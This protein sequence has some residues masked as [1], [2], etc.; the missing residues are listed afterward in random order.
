MK[1]KMKRKNYLIWATVTLLLTV[2]GSTG[3]WA[4]SSVVSVGNGTTASS[5]LPSYPNCRYALS[6]QI[7]TSDE[8]GKSGLITSIAFYNY[9]TGSERNYDI[10]LSHTSKTTFNGQTDWVQVAADNKV[11]SGKVWLAQGV[12]TVI[13][14]DTPFQYNG[15]QNLLI[16]IDDNTGE[17]TGSN[18]NVGTY[19]GSG[20]QALYYYKQFSTPLNLDPAQTVTEEGAVYDRK[21]RLQL[22]FETYP[23]PYKLTAPEI[24]DVSAQ[25]QCSLRGDATAWNLRYRKVGETNWTTLDN[26]TER[27]KVIE[28]LTA[29]TKYEAQVQAVFAGG[30]NSDWTESLIFTTNCC[31]AEE[32]STVNYALRGDYTPWYDFAV[33]IMDVTDAAK[34]VEAAYLRAPSYEL[35]K[36]SISLCSNHT[37]QVNWIYDAEH[38]NVNHSFAFDLTYSNGDALYSMDYFEAPE[39]TATLTTFVMD[40]GDFD[41]VMPTELTA[42]ETYQDATLGWTQSDNAR[43]WLVT[44]SKDPN[45]DPDEPEED[46]IVLAER[47]PFVLSELEENTTYYCAVRAVEVE[48]AAEAAPSRMTRAPE[49][50]KIRKNGTYRMKRGSKWVFKSVENLSR[51]KKI[52]LNTCDRTSRPNAPLD[53]VEMGKSKTSV[54]LDLPKARGE[55]TKYNILKKTVTGEGTEV[56]LSDIKSRVLKGD[57][58][59]IKKHQVS[60]TSETTKGGFDNVIFVSAKKGSE[61]TFKMSQ[62]K[63]GA[64]HEPYAVGWM[65]NTK[66]GISKVEEI[67]DPEKV[68]NEKLEEL[69]DESQRYVEKKPTETKMTTKIVEANDDTE[70]VDGQPKKP[71]E[72]TGED[73]V[74]FIRHNKDGGGYLRVQEVK[75]TEP[76]N[77]KEWTSVS[78]PEGQMWYVDENVPLG[79]TLLM[80]SEPVY[81]DGTTGLNSPI[82][83]VTTPSQELAPKPGLFSIAPG[84]TA[85]FSK[86]NLSGWRFEDDFSLSEKQYTMMGNGNMVDGYPADQVDLFALSTPLNDWGTWYGY[87]DYEENTVARFQGSFV[88]WGESESVVSLIGGGW[89]TLS[90]SEW[91][92]VLSGRDNAESRKAMVTVSD[93]KGLVLLPDEWE[94]PSEVAL[95]SGGIYTDEQWTVLED[96]GAVFL[97]AAGQFNDGLSLSDVG[98]KGYYWSSTP[99][100]DKTSATMK[101]DAYM[102]TFDGS[103]ATDVGIVSRRTGGAVRLVKCDELSVTTAASGFTT[104]VS[105]AT[106]DLAGTEGLSGYYATTVD[107]AYSSVTLTSIS[108]VPAHTPV[109]LKGSPNTTYRIEVT[110]TSN[111]PPAD[112]LLKGSATESTELTAG[113]AY[114]LSGG[115]FVRNNAGTMPAGK[116]YLPAVTVSQARQLTI[117]FDDGEMTAIH[118]VQSSPRQTGIYNLQGQ[119]VRTPGKGLYIINGK[120]VFIK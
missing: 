77:V 30:K 66:L 49:K 13:D 36:G 20:N 39:E 27:S 41:F 76:E 114:I 69:V 58:E 82:V 97:P 102:M 89:T 70:G 55:E 14:F 101:D 45:F 81:N 37:Y 108:L 40:D 100:D 33:Q 32:Q 110:V 65:S 15:T 105:N 23:K 112:N 78:L 7:Y 79:S 17:N 61:V 104:L 88:D 9:D 72:S 92:Y 109:V 24:G 4:Q 44:Y 73:G 26:L 90:S 103:G 29:T 52:I 19:N 80:K 116:A 21:N 35:Y 54:R 74:L 94:A 87:G 118:V 119:R 28:G 18:H 95:T 120:K 115:K 59:G 25:I 85:F 3:A 62:G 98:T 11:F 10:Y 34:P 38:E 111:T 68:S 51:S 8:I 64:T 91:Q 117:V 67:E 16:T 2:F 63:T 46:N 57:P 71:T 107:D 42:D 106:L 12:W 6:Q 84:K 47:N 1:R 60:I 113:E 50:V 43:Q 48:D 22:C 53:L 75:V 86:S 99:S 96:A 93:V 31:P 56:P 83:L 5:Y